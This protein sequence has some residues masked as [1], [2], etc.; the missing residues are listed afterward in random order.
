MPYIYKD[1]NG[2]PDF[3][4]GVYSSPPGGDYHYISDADWKAYQNYQNYQSLTLLSPVQRLFRAI[5]Q[6]DFPWDK[7]YVAAQ[8]SQS[9]QL[10][11]SFLFTGLTGNLSVD[12]VI[13]RFREL[14]QILLNENLLTLTT[15]EIDKIN[16]VVIEAGLDPQTIWAEP[17]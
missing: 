17:G 13:E 15:E 4:R 5:Q 10:A 9:A 14:I 2:K 12:F 6:P 8:K 11:L 3:E 1:S 7:L 16:A